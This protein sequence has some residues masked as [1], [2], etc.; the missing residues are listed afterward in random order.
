MLLTPLPFEALQWLI[1]RRIIL[2]S[3]LDSGP[4]RR[5]LAL[6]IVILPIAQI[7][8]CLNRSERPQTTPR[9]NTSYLLRLLM[10]LRSFALQSSRNKRGSLLPQVSQLRRGRDDA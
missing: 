7:R 6:K 10:G 4:L 3:I 2:I 1:S 5:A 9:C 8:R